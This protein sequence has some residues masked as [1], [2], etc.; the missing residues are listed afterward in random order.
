[1]IITPHGGHVVAEGPFPSQ[2]IKRSKVE[3]G[4]V[5]AENY[6]TLVPLKVLF[7]NDKF[8]ADDLVYVRST[9]SAET[10]SKLTY[11]IPGDDRDLLLVP[12]ER[13]VIAEKAS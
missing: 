1:M 13:I 9:D 7:A 8:E 10:W 6:W 5:S 4:V 2:T 12:I 11:R 3:G